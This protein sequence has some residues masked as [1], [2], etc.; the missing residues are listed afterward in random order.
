MDNQGSGDIQPTEPVGTD[1]PEASKA[2]EA[3]PKEEVQ[4]KPA[5]EKAVEEVK[6][7]KTVD[8]KTSEKVV[9]R[10]DDESPVGVNEKKETV[11]PVEKP[12]EKPVEKPKEEARKENPVAVYKPNTATKTESQKTGGEGKEGKTG[13]QGDDENKT[14]DKGDPRGTPDAKAMYG[15]PGTGGDGPGGSGGV[16]M[17]GFNGF[18]WPKVQAPSLPD[19]A[20]GVYE[21]IV[22]VD[23]NGDVISATP[24]KRGLSLEAERKLKAV[25][26][27]LEFVPKGTG[28]PPQSEGRITFKVV[29]K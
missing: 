3:K 23:E 11:K 2:E 20:Y 12:K 17:S 4:P 6:E 9:T 16:S 8:T 1:Q 14:G 26:Q 25:I 21:F 13:N 27:R 29:S 24:L 10:E 18:E 28:L 22:K 19:D 5:E 7:T 15:N